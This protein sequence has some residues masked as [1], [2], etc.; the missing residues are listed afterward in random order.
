MRF[1]KTHG[2]PEYSESPRVQPLSVRIIKKGEM[3][4]MDI[5]FD[6]SNDYE[7]S[8]PIDIRLR[9]ANLRQMPDRRKQS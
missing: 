1:I 5:T 4:S 3:D 2:E 7:K 6:S 9:G 8:Y